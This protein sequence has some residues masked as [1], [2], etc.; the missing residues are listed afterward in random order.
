[1]LEGTIRVVQARW[2]FANLESIT[3][4]AAKAFT[5]FS[6]AAIGSSAC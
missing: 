3:L 5:P 2:V 6:A 4:T 1:M